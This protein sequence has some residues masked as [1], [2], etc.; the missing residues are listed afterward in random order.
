M[1][2][3]IWILIIVLAVLCVQL[4]WHWHARRRARAGSRKV[5]QGK[6]AL[7]DRQRQTELVAD[8]AL[9]ALNCDV[10]WDNEDKVRVAQYEYQNGHFLLRVAPKSLFVR[11]SYL[12]CYSA[13]VEQINNVRTVANMCNINSENHRVV[14]S[15]NEEKNGV[16]VHIIA[17]VTL[18]PELAKETLAAAMA[19]A[20]GW[21]NALV[22]KFAELGGDGAATGKDEDVEM[23]MA[24]H[25]RELF[26]LRGQEMRR[27][28]TGAIRLNDVEHLT[29]EQ[30]LDKA[31]GLTAIVPR[32]LERLAP[33]ASTLED[34]ALILA[35]EMSDV[36][37]TEGKA[38][39]EAVL[40]LWAEIPQMPGE[41]RLITLTF[42]GE[43]D[44]GSTAYFRVTATLVPL[45]ASKRHPLGQHH[46][47]QTCC[48]VLMAYDRSPR[49]RQLEESN[50]MWKEAV[51]RQKNGETDSLTREQRLLLDCTDAG[52]AHLL[53]RG[54]Q[55]FLAGRYYEA[56][57][58][59]E[60]AYLV[61]R[62]D[63]DT[64]RKGHLETFYEVVYYIGFC[65]NQL[66]RYMMAQSY[67]SMLTHL[68]RISFT[69]E[70]VNSLVNA[71]DQRALQTIDE[72]IVSISE[73]YEFD[74]EIPQEHVARFMAF[75]KRRKAYVLVD[76]GFFKRAKRMLNEMLH[77]AENADFAINELAYIQKKEKAN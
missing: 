33:E 54:K 58:H 75:L 28:Q 18:H 21:Q 34:P 14:Y 29:L 49:S 77:E 9:K 35:F 51:Q 26:L 7:Q 30:F 27:Q 71:H 41:E 10:T 48:S 46:L 72:L 43:G 52:T 24:G 8:K 61:M 44:D 25:N 66:G 39:A 20:F 6:P 4:F 67:L 5:R 13:P 17:G 65:Y 62:P 23:E 53:Y 19:G 31:M 22:R 57:L 12:Y 42:N 3:S 69:M 15:I 70:Y 56:L 74:D 63:F 2:W 38:E 45:S 50:Y 59:L 73:S 36:L 37:M 47:M 60:N 1:D 55:L 40:L 68:H 64:M 11:L 16:D 32:R 76:K